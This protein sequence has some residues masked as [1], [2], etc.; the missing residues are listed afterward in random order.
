MYMVMEYG[1]VGG[2]W[3]GMARNFFKSSFSDGVGVQRSSSNGDFESKTSLN[4]EKRLGGM[5]SK[6]VQNIKMTEN[7]KI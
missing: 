7:C 1:W 3:K 6:Y 2:T 4:R 5:K